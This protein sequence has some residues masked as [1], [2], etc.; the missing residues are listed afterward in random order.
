LGYLTSQK[1]KQE[2]DD[3]LLI[4]ITPHVISSPEQ[5]D[6]PEIWIR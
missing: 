2:A 5:S 1:G 3:E 4:L 6:A